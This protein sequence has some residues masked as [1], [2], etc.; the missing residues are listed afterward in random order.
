[1]IDHLLAELGD[2]LDLTAEELADVIWL[3]LIRQEGTLTDAKVREPKRKTA[4]AVKPG[5]ATAPVPSQIPNPAPNT[6]RPG[7]IGSSTGMI[8]PRSSTAN[9]VLNRLPIKVANPPSLRNPLA[10]ARSLRPLMQKV[11]SGRV[12]GLDEQA[13]A[14]Q[15]AEAGI[16][17]PIVKPV[18]EP[19]FEIALVADESASMLIWRQTVLEFRKLLRNYGAFRDVQL[20]GLHCEGDRLCLRP[21]IGSDALQQPTRQPDEL[22]EPSGRRL[23]LLITDCVSSY[24]QEETLIKTL[25][26][27]AQQSPLAIAQVLPEWLW[28]RT[29]IRG[30]ESVQLTG[31]EPG[32]PSNQLVVDWSAVW[33][34]VANPQAGVCLPIVP[35][36]PDSVLTW[37]QMVMGRCEAPGYWLRS[38][39]SETDLPASAS[40][41][42]AQQLER[43]QLISSPVAQR[44]MGLVAASPVITLP[45]IRLIQETLLPKS[46]QM[47]V[48]EVLLGGLLEPI[49]PP[50]LGTIPDEMEYR[51]IDEAVRDLLLAETPVPD[52]VQVLSG[53]VERQFDQS[54]D[55]FVAE[56]Q[57]WTQNEDLAL[58]NKARS[59]ATV[60]AAVLKR[61]GGKYREFVQQVER[62]N[63]HHAIEEATQSRFISEQD[64]QEVEL[65][66]TWICELSFSAH[67]ENV[68]CVCFSPDGLLIASSSDD[69][70]IRLWNLQ[71][72]KLGQC[73]GHSGFVRSIVFSPNGHLL[74]S[75][76]NDETVRLWDL[77][78]NQIGQPLQGH[79]GVVT[80]IAFSPSG[81]VLASGSSDG[82]VRLWD[83]QG[84]PVDHPF[85]GHEG[86]V[87]SVA[88]SPNGQV[89]ASGSDDGTMRLW[90]L[91]GEPIGQPL[92]HKGAVVCVAFSRDS[93]LI[94]SGS[95]DGT[96]R[97]WN[98]KGN[99]ISEPIQGHAGTI[100]S[101]AFSPDGQ[102][103]VSS[104]QDSRIRV[105]NLEGNLIGEPLE[106][107]RGGVNSV[108]FSPDGQ[109]FASCS[110]DRSI[111]L[112]RKQD[113]EVTAV[114]PDVLSMPFFDA[115]GG[116][117]PPD[118]FIY[119]ERPPI[120]TRCYE[121]ISRPG[122]L[123][124]IKAPRQMGKT[125]LMAKILHYA[126]E[127]R[128]LTVSLNFQL[129][130]A[131][132]FNDLNQFLK[133]FCTKVG[134][135]LRL[136][137]RLEDY[138]D[139]VFGSM[140]NCTNYFEDFLLESI[141][142]PL[143]LC[144][145]EVDRV[146]NHPDIASDFFGL[147][148]GW[149]ERSRISDSWKKLRLVVVHSTEVYISMSINQSPFNVGL[150]FELPEFS[151]AQV[152]DLAARHGLDW[153]AEEV[154]LLVAMVGGQPYLVGVALYHLARQEMTLQQLL[155]TAP[156]ETGLYGEHLR[157]HWWILEQQPE[158]A[159]AMKHLVE[160]SGPVRLKFVQA[161]Q[162]HSM[163]LVHLQGN[164]VTFRNELYRRYFSNRLATSDSNDTELEPVEQSLSIELREAVAIVDE[165]E[166][167]ETLARLMARS[168]EAHSTLLRSLSTIED[169]DD[170]ILAL[171]TLIPHLTDDL[172][173][174]VP[175]R[176]IA[177]FQHQHGI[178]ADGVCGPQTLRAITEALHSS[179]SQTTDVNPVIEGPG[180]TL[181][182]Q[183]ESTQVYTLCTSNPWYLPLDALVIPVGYQGGLGNLAAD[184]QEFIGIRSKWL[185]D[186]IG[187][188]MRAEKLRRIK[189]DQPL[190]VQVPSEINTQISSLAGSISERFIICATSESE[191]ELSSSNTAIAYKSIIRL[192]IERNFSRIVV[193][194]IGTG[195]NQL[196]VDDVT[197]G[198]LRAIND[199]LTSLQPTNLEEITIV[200]RDE[201]KIA[202]IT[203]ISHA[204]S[205]S[206]I[207]PPASKVVE[208]FFSY[209]HR[210]EALRDEL[211]I[212]LTMLK[213]Q[214]IIAAWHDREITT[215]TEWAGEI[216]AHL[217][218][219]SIILLLVSADLLVSDYCYDLEM[220]RALQ[221]H[222]SGEALVIPLIL[223]SCD[224]TSAPFGKLQALPKNAKP[225]I[226]WRDREEAFLDISQGI[227]RAIAKIPTH[228]N[229]D[230]VA[231]TTRV[232][233][234]F[235]V[236][237]AETQ[238][239]RSMP[240][241][242]VEPQT[243]LFLAANPKDTSRLQVDQ[244]LRDI[245][246]GLQRAQKRDQFN[247]E[248][249]LAVRP[250]DIQRAMLDIGPQIIHFS[251]HGAGEAG[252]MFEDDI[253]NTKL[254]DGA[255]LAGLFELF[256]DQINCV[257]LN[258]C[259]SDVQAKAIGQHIPYVIGMNQAIGDKAAIAFAV[260][261]YD[262]LGAGRSIELAYKLGCAA[263]RLEGIAENLT[264]VLLQQSTT[265]DAI[266]QPQP[267]ESTPSTPP[268]P[269]GPNDREPIEVFISYSHK[270]ESLKDDLYMHL[271]NLTR[272]GKIKP[273]QDREIEAGTEWDAEI[274]ARL[275]SAS[276]ILLLITP[277][278][279]ASEYCFDKEM[280]RAMERHAAGTAR[281]IPIIMKPC[282][283]QDTAFSK[284]QVLP[285]DAKPVTSWS[286]PD[287]ALLDV[288]KG[289]RR[290]VD[291]LASSTRQVD[292]TPSSI[293]TQSVIAPD[294]ISLSDG[295]REAETPVLLQLTVEQRKALRAALIAAFPSQPQLELMVEDELEE[296]LNRITQGQSNYELAVRDLVKWA[297][298]GGKVQ[299][300]LEG[301]VQANP[302]NPKLQELAKLWLKV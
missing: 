174:A 56:L 268:A 91:F 161:F 117:I 82:T 216:D 112:W 178:L 250:R 134:D 201:D 165:Q 218:S 172:L 69:S 22:L 186:A 78:G 204:F 58:V 286:D 95:A 187:N 287:E 153:T 242:N 64:Q 2:K 232:S 40:R 212:H 273:W 18:L 193:P 256:S 289:I 262:A 240:S 199:V 229:E 213:Q 181:L 278:F 46:Q 249:R 224:W 55:E 34:S 45:V 19:W 16:W 32:V 146:F 219:A 125:S 106:G 253:G 296:S 182:W 65:A 210:D 39:P 167:A 30:F 270:D 168:P 131:D 21:G 23:I 133:W 301:A 207:E 51:F 3:T 179:S 4:A 225:V 139:D 59:F 180:R 135:E 195:R 144:L 105:W 147:L 77:Q 175:A 20:W 291:S 116:Q 274:K 136:P 276:V 271:A 66:S 290:A 60:T 13:T 191:H 156:T 63:Q 98:S 44:L 24:W 52:T 169:E 108:A 48:A 12:E 208:V 302:G 130:D 214:G 248:Q 267:D 150:A 57:L 277:R 295:R 164:D 226:E 157:R 223:R 72:E 103:L 209:S 119:V 243:I 292:A 143:T 128:Y 115:P 126:R 222:E 246:E 238:I 122:A 127:Q 247:L 280:Q 93:R 188:A 75:A 124:R 85:R 300:L 54:L 68:T 284:L 67:D 89:L 275:E 272:Q 264:P 237:E 99:P 8:T 203:R 35:L 28:V 259:Y 149:H 171:I 74:A 43:F 236:L 92:R 288:V 86:L 233:Q 76:G 110:G 26:R 162:L 190:L 107:H 217:N 234:D 101:I 299:S 79:E 200:D 244:E 114:E 148:R 96:L 220:Q 113:A 36:E 90:T 14:Q 17:Q 47:H 158:M 73:L 235:S 62:Q 152:Q 53:Y 41:P 197:T 245:A 185:S 269:P 211:A 15:I 177:I 71:G 254:V 255:A 297:E 282:D 160:A 132:I 123:I 31:L 100:Y 118:S 129:A 206:N 141:N 9:T 137:N 11:P 163:G 140:D 38:F 251:G 50:T 84:S 88:F 189:P 184:F 121:A 33:Q 279:I 196:S 142:S 260:G 42:P 194:L 10:L 7:T 228:N 111:R 97:L 263:I 1:M 80:S 205:V 294:S 25:K 70:T 166:R 265:G 87:N 202:A 173:S 170:R 298:S 231:A 49:V 5:V 104:S 230:R 293:T 281:V 257:V 83:L 145:D 198:A 81:Q 252:L 183:A 120:E 6:Q 266:G 29:A 159:V 154:T 94:A 102:R 261:F 37:S 215:G 27:W 285:R 155:E 283:W 61:K 176:D 151:V 138:W 221:R 109:L 241:S 192:A 239:N 258:G 227:L